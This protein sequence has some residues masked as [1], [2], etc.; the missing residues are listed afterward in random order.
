MP[1]YLAATRPGSRNQVYEIDAAVVELDKKELGVRTGP[2]LAVTVR[3]GR[4]GVRDEPTDSKDVVIMDAF[5]GLSVPWHLTTREVIAD[6][7]RVLRPEGLYLV[8]VIDNGQAL[9][10]KAEIKTLQAEFAQ[11]AVIAERDEFTGAAGGNFVLVGSDQP[12][13]VDKVAA[14]IG[15]GMEVRDQLTDFVGDAPVLTDDFAPVDQ[16]LTPYAS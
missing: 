11:V 14:G 12:I 9:F 8:N 2:D 7:K 5:S 13:N 1:R 6:V 3:D 4:L 15:P 16:L 10:A